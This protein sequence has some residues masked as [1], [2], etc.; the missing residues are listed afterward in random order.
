V[1]V[2]RFCFYAGGKEGDFENRKMR[3]KIDALY[4][5]EIGN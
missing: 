5:I 2:S 4:G 3:E 1:C